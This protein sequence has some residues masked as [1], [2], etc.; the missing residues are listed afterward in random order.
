MPTLSTDSY[1]TEAEYTTYAT[2]R[3]IT[4]D[5]STIDA[6][7]VLSADFISTYYNIADEYKLPD[8]ADEY[9]TLINKAALKAVELQQAGRL[10]IDYAAISGGLIKR[11][12][13]KADAL[14][15]EI[16]YQEGTTP[17][18][19]PRVPELDLLMRPFLAGGGNLGKKLV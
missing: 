10:T 14:E 3:G 1:T 2:A 6:D 7:L 18:Y 19:K 12:F 13:K 11:T 5:T 9:L 8:I 16:E 17:T 15:K 4:V